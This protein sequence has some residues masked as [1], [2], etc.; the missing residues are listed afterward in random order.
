MRPIRVL[1]GVLALM[2]ADSSIAATAAPDCAAM[3]R[4]LHQARTDFPSLR[5]AKMNPGKCSYRETEYR[6]AWYFPGDRFDLSDAQ[7]ARL[8]QCMAEYP[9][10]K[11]VKGKHNDSAFAVDPDLTIVM[12]RPELD[13][14]GWKVTLVIRSSWKPQ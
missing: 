3:V 6:C 10:A 1:A 4:L 5:R 13:G 12:P 14:D 7:A 9:A 2:L 11:P 8:V